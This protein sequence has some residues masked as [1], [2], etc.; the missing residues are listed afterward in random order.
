MRRHADRSCHTKG[1]LCSLNKINNYT[2]DIHV[3]PQIGYI[4]QMAWMM[5]LSHVFNIKNR[6]RQTH[7]C[8]H[9][10]N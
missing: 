2:I 9:L 8:V 7:E 6:I 5:F 4:F 1:S 3:V 10:Q